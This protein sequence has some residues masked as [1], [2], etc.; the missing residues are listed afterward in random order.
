MED[1]VVTPLPESSAETGDV[2][3][4]DLT[5]C[6]EERT[7][8]RIAHEAAAC[9]DPI[10]LIALCEELIEAIDLCPQ[11]LPSKLPRGEA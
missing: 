6:S 7:W 8:R 9:T 4:I 2:V 11:L 5:D 1:V 10:R 3:V